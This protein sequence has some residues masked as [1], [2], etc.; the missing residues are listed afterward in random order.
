M[1]NLF[2]LFNMVIFSLIWTTNKKDLQL[3]IIVPVLEKKMAT[4]MIRS[5]T[6]TTE[7]WSLEI[8]NLKWR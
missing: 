4:F 2:S 5:C 8:L 1:P 7:P 3:T 6:D